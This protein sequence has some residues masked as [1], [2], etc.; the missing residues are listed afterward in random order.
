MTPFGCRARWRA[1]FL[2]VI[3]GPLAACFPLAQPRLPQSVAAA[4]AQHPMRSTESEHLRLYF[5]E[6]REDEARRF[7]GAVEVCAGK[8]ARAAHV[9]NG[10][11]DQKMVVMLPELPFNNAFVAPRILGYD[12]EAVIPT[13]N[14]VDLFLLEMGLTPDPAEIACHELT[15]YVQFQQIAGFA[16]FV[17]AAFGATYSPQI[18]LDAWFDE[19]LAV[20][21]ETQLRTSTGRLRSPF[22]RGAF[23]AAFAG[24]RI[25]GGDLHALN[26]DFHAGNH[27]LV[28]SQF[29]RFLADRYGEDRLWRL[30]EVQAR[31]LFFPLWV[32][33]RF[34]QAYDKS[35]STLIDEFADEVETNLRPRQRPPGQR[36]VRAAGNSSRYARAADGTEAM[37]TQDQ[38]R[39]PRLIIHAPDGRVRVER[40]LVDVVPPRQL[41]IASAVLTSGLSFTADARSLYFVAVDLDATFQAA[42][43]LRYDLDTDRLLVV[44]RDVRGTGGSVTPDGTRYLFA[45]ANGD[46]HDLAELD[47]R[48]GGVRMLAPQVP[49]AFI[50]QPRVS[51]DGKRVVATQFDG[52]RFRIVVYDAVTGALLT[53]VAGGGSPAAEGHGPMRGQIQ[54]QVN[55]PSWIDDQRILFLGTELTDAGFQLYVHQLNGGYTSRVTNAPY[56]AFQPRAAGG[57]ALRFLNREGW[58]WTLDEVALPAP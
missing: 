45:Q 52:T 44:N 31:S 20:Y 21:Y 26:R 17:N 9:H 32:N 48:T 7:L 39:P 22:W 30:V 34:W 58:G 24:K 42:R 25:N 5:P 53:V 8:L 13:Y 12:T 49:G 38:D 50:G 55:D 3:S 56:L 33:L 15:H 4:L 36:V 35:L 57:R 51:P 10:I 1:A 54:G 41:A 47:L 19:G 18:G 14:T 43:L 6:G 23:A 27:Y 16:W 28:G 46:H 29:V 37:I 40:E 2:L 11:A